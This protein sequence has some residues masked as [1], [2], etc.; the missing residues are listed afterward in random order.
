MCIMVQ[1]CR[2][3]THLKKDASER[4]EYQ[5]SAKLCPYLVMGFRALENEP[6]DNSCVVNNHSL[7]MGMYKHSP[8]DLCVTKI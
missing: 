6:G 4:Q 5:V 1:Y 2:C 7:D 3:F 8:T